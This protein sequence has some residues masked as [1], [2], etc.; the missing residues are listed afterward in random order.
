METQVNYL[1]LQTKEQETLLFY[2]FNAFVC[3]RLDINKETDGDEEVNMYMAHLL[4]SMVDGRLFSEH[5]DRLGMTPAD[6]FQKAEEG[7]APRRKFEVYRANADHRLAFYCLFSGTGEHQSLYHQ[8]FTP[9]ESYPEEAQIYYGRAAL[10]GFRLPAR[11]QGVIL[12]MKKI[13]ANFEIYRSILAHMSGHY[14]DLRPCLTPGQLWHLERETNQAAGPGIAQIALDKMLDAY[15]AW[16]TNP[17]PE[18]EAEH[19]QACEQYQQ[20]KA[21]L[22]SNKP[23]GK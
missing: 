8:T 6:V 21:A 22:D 7:D 9:P 17:I 10:A 23:Q 5:A 15:N 19:R 12:A 4:F 2:M 16:Q 1:D 18:N 14:L 3:S 20:A 11:Y 13:A